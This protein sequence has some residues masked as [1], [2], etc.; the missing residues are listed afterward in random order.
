MRRIFGTILLAKLAD[1]EVEVKQMGEN[2]IM[3]C[4]NVFTTIMTE[5]L[6]TPSKGH[7]IFNMRDLAK[8]SSVSPEVTL[9]NAVRIS[10][11]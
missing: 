8:V 11:D 4:I 6:P 9:R 3:V 10:L 1:F 2:L 5:L 7:Y